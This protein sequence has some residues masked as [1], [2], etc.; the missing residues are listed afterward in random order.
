M[1]IFDALTMPDA[2]LD[3]IIG[4]G[5]P[6]DLYCIDLW[7]LRGA[8]RRRAGPC[9]SLEEFR[10]CPACVDDAARGL[11][12]RDERAREGRLARAIA[13]ARSIRSTDRLSAAFARRGFGAK[14]A[15]WDEPPAPRSPER[16]FAGRRLGVFA[17]FASADNDRLIAALGRRLAMN[18]VEEA[19]V[20]VFGACLNEAAATAS[21]AVFVAGP[22][23]PDEYLDLV[24]RYEIGKLAVLDRTGVFDL[25]DRLS[26][27]TGAPKAY[28]NSALGVIEPEDGDLALDPRICDAKAAAAIASWL[29]TAN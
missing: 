27:A 5:A 3:L 4:L 15:P 28:F 14:A 13:A 11:D 2:L 24:Q 26:A 19:Q 12:P 20:I 22:T 7:T 18:G 29:R 8:S 10:P 17:P 16:F 1:E 21:G 6:I 23:A 25:V 9:A